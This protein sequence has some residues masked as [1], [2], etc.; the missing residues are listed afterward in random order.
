MEL[1]TSVAEMAL[2]TS[3]WQAVGLKVG[4]VPTMG[5][6]HE[7]HISLAKRARAEND[8]VVASIFVNP[9]QFGPKEDFSR[10][11][12]DLERDL[13]LLEGAGVDAVF[14]PTPQ[15]M[16]PEGFNASIEVLG[17]TDVLEG[18]HRPGHF[19][20]VTTVVA[21]LF[22]IVSPCKAY[23]GQKDAQQV[24]VIKKMVRDLNFPLEI[25]IC[26]TLREADGL[27]MSSRNIYLSVDE[28]KA[29]TVLYRALTAAQTAFENGNRQGDALR[30]LMNEVI[31]SETLAKPDYVSVANP[32]DLRE[33]AGLIPTGKGV[34]LSMA[35]RFGS[36]RLIDN[37]QL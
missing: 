15:E 17:I 22:N 7:G 8:K 24:A 19:K 18:A 14:H 37:F 31:S 10:Y 16:Y 33:Y 30:K 35:V 32:E 23:F 34:L 27:A 28:R 4:L 25:V 3:N 1:I 11:P 9:L 2:A 6:L 13:N 5:Y 36:T 21:K 12:R 29:A 20:G 26:P